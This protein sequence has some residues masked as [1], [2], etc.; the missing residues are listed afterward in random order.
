MVC[1]LYLNIVVWKN[2]PPALNVVPSLPS[3]R[4][5][6]GAVRIPVPGPCASPPGPEVLLSGAWHSLWL[7]PGSSTLPLPGRPAPDLVGILT[8]NKPSPPGSG[9]RLEGE[10]LRFSRAQR[11]VTLFVLYLDPMTLFS[12]LLFGC[13]IAL[14]K[15]RSQGE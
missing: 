12:P 15:F 1:K 4:C 8:R 2:T 3:G 14:L 5:F 7:S 11:P 6:C 10:A 13:F 9:A